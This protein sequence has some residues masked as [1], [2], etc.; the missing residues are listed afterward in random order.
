MKGP[1]ASLSA[2][3]VAAAEPAARALV[4]LHGIYGRGRNWQG[5]ARGLIEARP[6]YECWLV[7]LPHHGGSGP[8]RHG[9]GIGGL[10]AD[11]ADWMT[12]QG[13]PPTAVLGH[14]YG[15]K[16]ALALAPLGHQPVRQVWVIDSTPEARPPSGSAWDLLQLVRRLPGRF[17]SRE[18]AIDGIVAGGFSPEVARWMA[19]NLVRRGG[20]MVWRLDFD[21]MARLLDDFFA[22]DLWAIVES[23]PAGCQLHFLKASRSSAMS[24][25][26]V[27]RIAARAGDRLRLHHRDGGHWIHA[28]APD[29]VVSL[30]AEHL[31]RD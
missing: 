18:Q 22:T 9:D 3:R 27:D 24:A 17:A 4:M 20:A 16:V 29:V 15:G 12:G 2:T 6:D 1:D 8:G 5:V 10:A 25:T 7:D 21:V 19:T 13:L 23:P 31:P 14:S 30:L 11:V 26:A 28:E